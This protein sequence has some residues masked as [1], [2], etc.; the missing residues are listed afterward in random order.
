MTDTL[1]NNLHYTNK[2]RL[3]LLRSPTV[4]Y[5]CT[6]VEFPSISLTPI[7][8]ATPVGKHFVGGKVVDFGQFTFTFTMDEDFENYMNIF[9][10]MTGIAGSVDMIKYKELTT[11]IKK[12][13]F[14]TDGHNIYSDGTLFSLTN[15]SNINREFNIINM[16]PVSL[17]SPQFSR[18]EGNIVNTCTAT[19]QCDYFELAAKKS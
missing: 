8:L 19:F 1:N 11:D 15:A 14:G 7:A 4:Q 13:I 6:N 17:G 12:N 5:N 16:F 10:W 3:A 9:N 18:S 2:W